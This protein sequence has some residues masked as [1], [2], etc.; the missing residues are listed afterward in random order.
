MQEFGQV[1][2]V[3]LVKHYA[4]LKLYLL[5]LHNRFEELDPNFV[6]QHLY[7]QMCQHQVDQPY[8]FQMPKG[9]IEIGQ[10]KH[11]RFN[12]HKNS[13]AYRT[14]VAAWHPIDHN[15]LSCL[16]T[17]PYVLEVDQ[18]GAEGYYYAIFFHLSTSEQNWHEQDKHQYLPPRHTQLSVALLLGT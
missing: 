4:P 16:L 12:F 10:R 18:K 13:K 3:G 1:T 7:V 2:S 6:H 11:E 15:R 8:Q 17:Y 5:M 14:E 9:P